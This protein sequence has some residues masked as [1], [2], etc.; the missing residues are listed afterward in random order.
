MPELRQN[1]ITGEWVVI[2]PERAKRPS[3]YV[4]A[5]ELEEKGHDPCRFCIDGPEYGKRIDGFE[6][7]HTYVL[8]NAYPVFVE[9][10]TNCSPRSFVTEGGLYAARPSTGGHDVVV[11]KEHTASLPTFSHQIWA[12][13]LEMTRRRVEYFHQIC[14]VV[15]TVPIYNHRRPA[16]AS[17]RHPHAQI[18]AANVV[19]NMLTRE[20]HHTE[21]YFE[22][23]GTCAFCEMIAHERKENIRIIYDRDGFI[24][25]TCY[26]ARFPF[27][28]WILPTDHQSNYER[29]THVQM[30][31]LATAMKEIM[32]KLDHILQDPPL[33][34]FIHTLPSIF[35]ESAH[36]HWHI[37]IAPRLATYGGFEMGAGMIIDVMSPEEAA[38]E[39][40]SSTSRL[41][42]V[43]S[44][45]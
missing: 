26:A 43:R 17:V 14:N 18:F 41:G 12:D 39:L 10:P 25:F 4:V 33:N 11:V 22:Q 1:F 28:I 3:D 42:V 5:P 40:R 7:E 15:S 19:P 24:A 31:H 6:N 38:K 9:N 20:L 34:Y 27:E 30:Q 29:S 21:R 36:Y 23:H 37:E 45:I 2:S 44:E 8:P 13:L 32:G 35:H 16:G